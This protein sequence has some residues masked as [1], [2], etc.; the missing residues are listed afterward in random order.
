MGWHCWRD[1]LRSRLCI[2]WNFV[3]RIWSR[4][5]T[6]WD[7]S[8]S[9]ANQECWCCSPSPWIKFRS[10]LG[11]QLEW[12]LAISPFGSPCERPKLPLQRSTQCTEVYSTACEL[13]LRNWAHGSAVVFII[14]PLQP[15]HPMLLACRTS[16]AWFSFCCA[17]EAFCWLHIA[18]LGGQCFFTEHTRF[19]NQLWLQHI[20][21]TFLGG[22]SL[23]Q[24]SLSVIRAGCS[25]TTPKSN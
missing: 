5:G 18:A 21:C 3:G 19:F 23:L 13:V 17:F 20:L 11:L 9:S 24:C 4:H 6:S 10:E 16:G 12:T 14:F 25:S 15:Q 22:W 2:D 8:S 7:C 1:L